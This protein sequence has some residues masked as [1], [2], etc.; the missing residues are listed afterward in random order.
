MTVLRVKSAGILNGVPFLF[1]EIASPVDSSNVARRVLDGV[2]YVSQT[3]GT[4]S[5]PPSRAVTD[6]IADQVAP[7]Y[8][9]PN[10][11]IL[12]STLISGN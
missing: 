6:W 3:V 1:K 11:H 4:Y 10:A 12:V 7:D 9:V 2:K 8:W 5:A